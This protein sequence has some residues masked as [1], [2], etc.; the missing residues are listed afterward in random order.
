MSH[1]N[2]S[3]ARLLLHK[4]KKEGSKGK[5]L[6]GRASLHQL[7]ILPKNIS[8]SSIALALAHRQSWLGRERRGVAT[9][10]RLPTAFEGAGDGFQARYD[11]RFPCEC[12]RE[13]EMVPL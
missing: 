7:A 10:G 5:I 8:Q 1:A 2:S 3:A 12:V 9:S 13:M 6:E 4:V 11:R